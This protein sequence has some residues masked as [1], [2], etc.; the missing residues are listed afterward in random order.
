MSTLRFLK[1]Y[2]KHPRTVGALL[3]SSPRL[4][5]QMIAPINFEQA[6]CIVEYGPG[7]GVFTE[8]IIRRK[9]EDTVLLI[10]EYNNEFYHEL[11]RKYGRIKNVHIVCDSAEHTTKYLQQCNIQKVDYVV[12]G[13]PFTSLPKDVSK[14]ILQTTKD[15][16]GDD[17][18]LILFQYSRFK[19]NLLKTFFMNIRTKRVLQNVPPAFVFT[20]SK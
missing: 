1:E 5:K 11:Q 2:I 8:E 13:L 6:T 20:C 3:P 4:V 15:L 9:R 10:I 18:D 12:S 14:N 16:L 19:Q 17:G 7:T